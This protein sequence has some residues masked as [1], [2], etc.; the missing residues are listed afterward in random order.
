[1][2]FGSIGMAVD[3]LQPVHGQAIRRNVA[4]DTSPVNKLHKL[5]NGPFPQP[6]PAAWVMNAAGAPVTRVKLTL[7]NK[8]TTFALEQ[9][10]ATGLYPLPLLLP[11][12]YTLQVHSPGY[13]TFRRVIIVYPNQPLRTRVVLG[14]PGSIY[15]PS[16]WGLVLLQNPTEIVSFCGK[17]VL[18]GNGQVHEQV[19]QMAAEFRQLVTLLP[20]D[21]FYN[22][23]S[24]CIAWPEALAQRVAFQQAI[25][26][27]TVLETA[28]LYCNGYPAEATPVTRDVECRISGAAKE[29][30]IRQALEARHFHIVAWQ[31]RRTESNEFFHVVSA[32]YQLPLSLDYLRQIQALY[33]VLPVIEMRMGYIPQVKLSAVQAIK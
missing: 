10:A 6:G 14:R 12:L 31:T 27:S 21:C 33:N 7:Q 20:K 8:D 16:P 32:V 5:L 19:Q 13:D 28:T 4:A 26:R 11:G 15:F 22:E 3:A 17:A 25:E 24:W 30:D 2:L 18:P 23:A 1:M 9:D 29:Q